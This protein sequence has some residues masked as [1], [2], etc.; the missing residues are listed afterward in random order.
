M[1]PFVLQR[2]AQ[3]EV[4]FYISN[5]NFCFRG[6]EVNRAVNSSK[7]SVQETLPAVTWQQF[8]FILVINKLM[9]CLYLIIIESY[10]VYHM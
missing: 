3:W 1:C 4:I 2:W 6:S 7:S 9:L 5:L 10:P 8:I